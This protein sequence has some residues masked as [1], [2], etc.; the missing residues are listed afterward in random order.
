ML[1]RAFLNRRR[2]LRL[3]NDTLRSPGFNLTLTLF[4]RSGFTPRLQQMASA[5]G[6]GLRLVDVEQ[7]YEGVE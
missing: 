2:E 1:R 3:I 7:M 5:E 4:S 6:E